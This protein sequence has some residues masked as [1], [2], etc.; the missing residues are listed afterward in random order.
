MLAFC[1]CYVLSTWNGAFGSRTGKVYIAVKPSG[2]T[3]ILS[4]VA[5]LLTPTTQQYISRT[6]N[7]LVLEIYCCV[8]GVNNVATEESI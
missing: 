4:S 1:A 6:S 7:L 2:L 3:Q 8:V 5:T